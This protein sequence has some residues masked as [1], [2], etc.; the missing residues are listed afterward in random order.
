[1]QAVCKALAP[2]LSTVLAWTAKQRQV[3]AN[4]RKVFDLGHSDRAHST[5]AHRTAMKPIT[6]KVE[7]CLTTV[8]LAKWMHGSQTVTD[9]NQFMTLTAGV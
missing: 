8:G 6:E 4:V 9:E 3:D 2:F 7:R 5:A 1:M